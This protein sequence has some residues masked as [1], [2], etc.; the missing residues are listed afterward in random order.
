MVGLTMRRLPS[1][2]PLSQ[3]RRCGF[4]WTI[5]LVLLLPLGTLGQSCIDDFEAIYKREAVVTDTSVPRLYILCPRHVYEIGKLD[6][7]GNLVQPPGGKAVM[8]P[9]PLRPN[10]TIRCGD[11]GLR[12]NVCWVKGGDLHLDG[13][14]ILGITDDSLENVRIE[15]LVFIGAGEYSFW[16]NKP[17]SVT[18]QD[19]EFREFTNS[20]APIMLDFYDASAPSAE[21]VTT[22]LDCEFR[23]R[24]M[25]RFGLAVCR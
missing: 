23:V 21:L 11:Q 7:D 2:R 25:L 16:G 3:Y 5:L 6:F 14:K 12:E 24:R 13:T 9:L 1:E 15:G 4:L 19:C 10:M 17:G 22:F 20:S 18:F 8:P